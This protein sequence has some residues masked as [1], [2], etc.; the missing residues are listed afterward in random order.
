ERRVL[1][2]A[3]F[4]RGEDGELRLYE[5]GEAPRV[6]AVSALPRLD[7][8]RLDV[9]AA[10]ARYRVTG[11]DYK[12]RELVRIS[13]RAGSDESAETRWASPPSKSGVPLSSWSVGDGDLVVDVERMLEPRSAISLRA[14]AVPPWH[15]EIWRL[16]SGDGPQR[17]ASTSLVVRCLPT[18]TPHATCLAVGPDTT[19]FWSV[20]PR[21][22]ALAPLVSLRGRAREEAIAPDGRIVVWLAGPGLTLVDA[23][24]RSAERLKLP[25][26]RAWGVA[27]A[28]TRT[29]VG[30]FAQGG[31]RELL[32]VAR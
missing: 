5:L 25:I 8:A 20:D 21:R 2:L 18:L 12:S 10:T 14:D 32:L 23:R 13:G 16:L 24:A 26:E 30:V 6:V 3:G 31:E 27:L 17:L 7:S 9:D 15:S 22:D 1:A 28:A 19:Y 11:I 4:E 29:H